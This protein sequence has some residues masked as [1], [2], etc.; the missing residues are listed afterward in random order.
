[1]V[2][3][4]AEYIAVAKTANLFVVFFASVGAAG[5]VEFEQDEKQDCKAP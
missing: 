1:M 4:T 3:A 5:G 2:R